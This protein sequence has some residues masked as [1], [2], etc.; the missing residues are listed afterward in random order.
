MNQKQFQTACHG[1]TLTISVCQSI[2]KGI[3]IKRINFLIREFTMQITDFFESRVNEYLNHFVGNIILKSEKQ[4]TYAKNIAGVSLVASVGTPIFAILYYLMGLN[5]CAAGIL[6]GGS[7]IMLAPYILKCTQSILLSRTIAIV[8]LYFI[9][10]IICFSMQ[11]IMSACT[12]WFLTMPVA[13]VFMGGMIPGIFWAV[14]VSATIIFMHYYE[15]SGR[16]FMNMVADNPMLL[17]T[18]SILGLILV[19]TSLAILF[20]SSKN[21]SIKQ[22]KKAKNE[23]EK[24][25]GELSG[26]ISLISESIIKI[27]KETGLISERTEVMAD[28]LVDQEKVLRSSALSMKDIAIHT[29]NNSDNAGI[30]KSMVLSTGELAL[31]CEQIMRELLQ[32]MIEVSDL[33]DNVI[34]DLNQFKEN[35]GKETENFMQGKTDEKICGI[36]KS[37]AN[38]NVIAAKG[39]A[40]AL[41]SKPTIM[42]LL[43]SS[44]KVTRLVSQVYLNSHQQALSNDIAA[45][46]I[47]RINNSAKQISTSSIEIADSVKS[48]DDSIKNLECFITEITK[49]K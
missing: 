30:A 31:S 24:T 10:L 34:D 47:S 4:R 7:G 35:N 18:A 23:L 37:I 20:D 19:I 32:N 29:Q 25:A 2:K 39:K 16:A 5:I 17:Q 43:S 38:I 8:S 28:T 44:R 6:G 42:D 13:A 21:H 12:Y 1:P 45:A 36:S 41:N 46:S 9:F 27:K 3:G 48:L 15:Q 49:N 26:L 14:I 22:M 40:K 11:G 33:S